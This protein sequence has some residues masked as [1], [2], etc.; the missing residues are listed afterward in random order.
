MLQQHR[1][2]KAVL[3]KKHCHLA[4]ECGRV[5]HATQEEAQFFFV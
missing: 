2:R 4:E 1:G 5:S 3:M